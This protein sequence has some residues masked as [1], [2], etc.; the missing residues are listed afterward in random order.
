MS[1]TPPA[2]SLNDVDLLYVGDCPAFAF[3]EVWTEEGWGGLLPLVKLFTAFWGVRVVV[4]VR[5]GVRG[6]PPEDDDGRIA[7]LLDAVGDVGVLFRR[8]VVV[9]EVGVVNEEVGPRMREGRLSLNL[10]VDTKEGDVDLDM[11]S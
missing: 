6:D 10:G 1:E 9:K 3:K 7:L 11:L 4:I 8:G 2:L 5:E